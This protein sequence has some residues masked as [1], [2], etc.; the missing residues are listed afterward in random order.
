MGIQGEISISWNR[1][2]I[3]GK[4]VQH[5]GCFYLCWDRARAANLRET[6][7]NKKNEDN[8]SAVGGTLDLKVAEQ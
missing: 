5:F 8:Q 1:E 2:G 4:C 7:R 6:V 3:H